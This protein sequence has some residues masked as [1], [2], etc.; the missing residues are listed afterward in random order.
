MQ[1][2]GRDKVIEESDLYSLYLYAVRSP[3]TRD[4]YLRKLCSLII[5]TYFPIVGWKKGAIC[6]LMPI[7]IR[8]YEISQKMRWERRE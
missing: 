5:L 4:Y 7:G 3:V 2:E 1:I 8:M 6:L